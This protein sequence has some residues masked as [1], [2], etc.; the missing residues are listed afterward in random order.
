M[1]RR[2]CSPA[3]T[4]RLPQQVLAQP[5]RKDSGRGL[6]N[7]IA[8]ALSLALRSRRE[9]VAGFGYP[10]CQLTLL[11]RHWLRSRHRHLS[12]GLRSTYVPL[13]ILIAT[14]SLR[15][16]YVNVICM[17]GSAPGPSTV[18]N[19]WQAVSRRRCLI[20]WKANL[21]PS[22]TRVPLASLIWP[23]SSAFPRACSDILAPLS[24][25]RRRHSYE[26]SFVMA[27]GGASNSPIIEPISFRTHC[28]TASA[29]VHRSMG[30]G[31]TVIRPLFGIIIPSSR[32]KITSPASI[33]PA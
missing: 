19:R 14:C 11:Q 29:I 9:R 32:T 15:Q 1:Y 18:V 13:E 24:L 12:R 31:L 28:A 25:L 7:H 20:D 10:R 6:G 26:P 23:R 21:L 30:G 4:R 16:V 27:T 8:V 2:R 17:K 22:S 5:A 33:L 3:P